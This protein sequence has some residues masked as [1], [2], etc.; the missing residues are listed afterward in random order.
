MNSSRKPIYTSIQ[1][2][3]FAITFILLFI[4]MLSGPLAEWIWRAKSKDYSF[5][6][7]WYKIFVL[8]FEYIL[9]FAAIWLN[10]S[11]L[12]KFNI[13]KPLVTIFIFTGLLIS[14]YYLPDF[15]VIVFPITFMVFWRLVKNNFKFNNVE[16]NYSQTVLIFISGLIPIILFYFLRLLFDVRWIARQPTWIDLYYTNLPQVLFEEIAF[17]GLLW[18]CLGYLGMHDNK[19]FCVQALLFWFL[20][21]N[22]WSNP[23]TFWIWLPLGS[24]WLSLLVLRTKSLTLSTIGHFL[25][26]FITLLIK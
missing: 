26:N 12:G 22:Y 17:R 4:L 25:F 10:G 5:I 1:K 21:I 9:V 18:A 16:I 11:S 20:H 6:P 7:L 8:F 2:V 19:I 23:I 3:T 14:I 24:L 13:D 15:S